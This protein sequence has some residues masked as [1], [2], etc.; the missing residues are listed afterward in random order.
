MRII[1]ALV[2]LLS[3]LLATPAVAADLP[4][5]KPGEVGLSS[6]RLERLGQALRVDVE[7]GRIPGAV[8]VIARRGRVAFVQVAG[9]R[10]PAARAPMTPDAI[11]RLASMTK[12]MVTAARAALRPARA[13]ARL[14]S[15]H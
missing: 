14:S 7:Q 8:V 10:D 5:A 4:T 3:L 6:E 2:L 12:P 13:R 9:F 1:Q 11:F 15:H